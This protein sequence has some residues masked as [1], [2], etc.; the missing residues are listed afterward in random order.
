[1]TNFDG[2]FGEWG[3]QPNP[4]P[5]GG[6]PNTEEQTVEEDISAVLYRD[7]LF[8]DEYE[9]MLNWGGFYFAASRNLPHTQ[10]RDH[11]LGWIAQ[12]WDEHSVDGV[13]EP[14]QRRGASRPTA[15]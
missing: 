13:L 9:V 2:S 14:A 1:M 11:V 12:K 10:T 7:V 15:R 4:S 5:G 8:S 3:V 6:L